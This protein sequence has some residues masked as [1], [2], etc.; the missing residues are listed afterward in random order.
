[1]TQQTEK[2][3][4]EEETT[5]EFKVRALMLDALSIV[6]PDLK[7]TN[8]F[9]KE[10]RFKPSFDDVFSTFQAAVLTG[11][12]NPQLGVQT[13]IRFVDIDIGFDNLTALRNIMDDLTGVWHSYSTA[14]ICHH[15]SIATLLGRVDPTELVQ[16]IEQDF[17]VDPIVPKIAY[18]EP[19]NQG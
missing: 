16:R 13:S 15:G 5:E 18:D 6:Y 4:Y 8:I 1:M 12:T 7:P 2:Y 10:N 19:S 11:E 17:K 3:T 9:V 14:D